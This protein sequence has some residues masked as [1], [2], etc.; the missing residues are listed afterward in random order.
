MNFSNTIYEGG[1]VAVIRNEIITKESYK[2]NQ[3]SSEK[4]IIIKNQNGVQNFGNI[5]N[6][7]VTGLP[8]GQIHSGT[9][10]FPENLTDFIVLNTVSQA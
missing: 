10:I 6:F 5:L 1:T 2:N 7:P 3:A 9:C 4:K 8:D